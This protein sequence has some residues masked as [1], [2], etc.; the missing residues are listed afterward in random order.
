MPVISAVLLMSVPVRC[1]VVR[2]VRGVCGVCGRVE[3]AGSAECTGVSLYTERAVTS[4]LSLMLPNGR[5]RW[6]NPT[7]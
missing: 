2:G 4:F 1:V 6:H 7:T 3:Y 5:M